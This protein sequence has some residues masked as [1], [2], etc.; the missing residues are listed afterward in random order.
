MDQQW[1][2]GQDAAKKEA[3]QAARMQS[4]KNV[5]SG[6]E[7]LQLIS[8]LVSGKLKKMIAAGLSSKEIHR[9]LHDEEHVSHEDI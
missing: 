4:E 8:A 1:F 3:E 5:G 9:R 6:A 2:R 7:R